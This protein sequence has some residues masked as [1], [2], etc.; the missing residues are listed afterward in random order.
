MPVLC[1]DP[2]PATQ[3]VIG[4]SPERSFVNCQ[5]TSAQGGYRTVVIDPEADTPRKQIDLAQARQI[6]SIDEVTPTQTV[7]T[8]FPTCSLLSMKR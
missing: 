8:I 4:A 6:P 5:V 7:T 2:N 1:P 3:T